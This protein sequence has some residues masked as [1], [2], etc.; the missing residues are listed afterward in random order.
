MKSDQR[1]RARL[2]A[3]R[4]A[5]HRH[6]LSDAGISHRAF[7]LQ[8]RTRLR[9]VSFTLRRFANG[10]TLCTPLLIQIRNRINN[11]GMQILG[12]TA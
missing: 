10:R 4:N 11:I 9:N 7:R 1:P 2:L 5:C 6:R 3:R 12:T 8:S